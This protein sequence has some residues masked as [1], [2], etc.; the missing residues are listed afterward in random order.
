MS[1]TRTDL[2]D[3]RQ[4]TAAQ[5]FEL[6]IQLKIDQTQPPSRD[7]LGSEAHRLEAMAFWR[8]REHPACIRHDSRRSL[9]DDNPT[10]G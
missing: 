9:M 5:P 1:P 6:W 2:R 7:A 3:P 8:V 10:S 4:A